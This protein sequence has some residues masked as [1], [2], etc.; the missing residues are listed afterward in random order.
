MPAAGEQGRWR[1]LALT[2]L[3]LV[4]S[5]MTWFS[6]TAVLPEFVADRGLSPTQ[7]IWLTNAVQAGFAFGAL[8]SS[9]LALADIW[10]VT[11]IMAVA[12][13]LAALANLM[14]LADMGGMTSVFSRFFTGVA[15]AGIYP[16]ALKF[17]STWFRRGR[18]M[19]MGAMVGALTFGSA[20]PHLVRAGGA[21]LHWE[22][23][24]VTCSAGGLLAAIVFG[25]LLREGPHAHARTTVDLRQ[26]GT[27]IRNKPVMLAN[28]GYFGH[29]WELYAVWGWFLAYAR[30]AS[31]NGL[32]LANASLLTFGLIAM[33]AAGCMIGG[34]MADRVGRCLTT[35]SMLAVSG[36]SALLI[37]VFYDGPLWAFVAIALIWGFSVVADSAQFS[38]AVSELA[39]PKLVGSSLAF[40][41]GVGFT[42]SI[43]ATWITPLVA[44][45][46]GSWRWTFIIL[47]PGPI[48]GFLAMLALR[49]NPASAAMAGGRR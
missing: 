23:I 16:P 46:L 38:A 3:A 47:A 49:R 40:Q 29:M 12:A 33:G 15:L 31:A 19:A 10:P 11:R 39:N 7:A 21:G 26:I 9:F 36:A 8:A 5:L 43:V 32:A 30:N 37:G 28:A 44:D 13:I 4:L 41:M 45:L 25:L 42:I 34:L 20:L 6:A 35:M 14:L 2:G 17:I 24:V 48:L 22:A 27:I 1:A 18:G